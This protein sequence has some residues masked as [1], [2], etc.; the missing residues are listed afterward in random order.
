MVREAMRGDD[1]DD[2]DEGGGGDEDGDDEEDDE[3][4]DVD[5][6]CSSCV[7]IRLT[8]AR[9]SAPTS[10]EGTLIVKRISQFSFEAQRFGNFFL[11]N[12]TQR[13]IV[14]LTLPTPS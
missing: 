8:H 13:P 9:L 4:D 14:R 2:D 7:H 12:A 6:S 10:Y 1:D 11:V 5:E 3:D